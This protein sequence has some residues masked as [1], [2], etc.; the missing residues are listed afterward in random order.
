MRRAG[1]LLGALALVSLTSRADAANSTSFRLNALTIERGALACA[2]TVYCTPASPKMPERTQLEG[3]HLCAG[4][5]LANGSPTYECRVHV[6]A[7]LTGIAAR[8][9]PVRLTF[10]VTSD[11]GNPWGDD[12]RRALRAQPTLTQPAAAGAPSVCSIIP[13]ADARITCAKTGSRT[14]TVT[15]TTSTKTGLWSV[16]LLI[17]FPSSVSTEPSCE[18][19]RIKATSKSGAKGASIDLGRKRYCA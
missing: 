13:A 19:L 16:P 18:Y 9:V 14:W 3:K 17:A 8:G 1:V 7:T 15:A 12:V 2:S 5:S 6:G 4:T 11:D 10:S